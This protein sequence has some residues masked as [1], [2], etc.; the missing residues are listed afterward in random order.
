MPITPDD[1]A[2]DLR[3]KFSQ[4]VLDLAFRNQIR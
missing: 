1:R 3:R 4:Q 2:E